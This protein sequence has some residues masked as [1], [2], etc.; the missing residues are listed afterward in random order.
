MNDGPGIRTTIFMKGCPLRCVWCHNPEGLE[1]HAVRMF[2]PRK[3]IGCQACVEACPQHFKPTD[4]NAQCTSCRR[5]TDACPTLAL[6]MAGKEWQLEQ[7]MAEVERERGVM[8]ESGGGVTLCGG[9]PLMHPSQVIPILQELKTRGFHTTVD[10]TLFTTESV[11]NDIMPLTDLFLIDLKHMDCE[12]H[13]RFTR[14]SNET[15]LNN[16][17]YVSAH[18]ARFWIRIPLIDGINADDNNLQQSASFIAS[19]PNRPEMVNLLPYHD[20]G[21]GKH[22]RL[23]TTYNP[24]NITMQ[25]PSDALL[26]HAT[27]I[28][29]SHDIE[30]RIGG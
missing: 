29:A 1:S 7:L 22:T 2:N 3:C 26:A 28:F 13:K 24:D 8:E 14:V 19:L 16:I 6:Q 17:K 30:V 9:E 20:T 12:A 10:T 23:G 21:K 5:C 25:T 18:S 11:L 15:I 27:E 4:R